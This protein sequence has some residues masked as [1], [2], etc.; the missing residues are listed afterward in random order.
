MKTLTKTV[1]QM[2]VPV[3]V[4]ASPIIAEL[5][6]TE[7]R[8]RQIYLQGTSAT[9]AEV[10]ALIGAARTE[11]PGAALPC[12]GC[13]GKNGQGQPQG[14]LAPANLSWQTLSAPLSDGP[15]GRQRPAYT[16]PLL[17]RAITRGLDSGDQQ[18]HITMPRY[19][20][21]AR[22]TSDLIAYL[23]SLTSPPDPD[24]R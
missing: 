2:I 20:L 19:R 22:D 10:V 5:S 13:H 15:N 24:D 21:T 6:E 16:E 9:G 11:L 14:D 12:G 4:G 8:G 1:I 18:L 7:H 3:L 17:R 23:R